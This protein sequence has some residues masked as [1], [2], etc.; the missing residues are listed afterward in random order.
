MH[1]IKGS[2][3]FDFLAIIPFKD[4]IGSNQYF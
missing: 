4:V 3:I 1:Y 2:C